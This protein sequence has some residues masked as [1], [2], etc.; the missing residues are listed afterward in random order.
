MQTAGLDVGVEWGTLNIQALKIQMPNS[1]S[2]GVCSVQ[3]LQ[4]KLHAFF[5]KNH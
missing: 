2:G 5:Y 4:T 3:K 1:L